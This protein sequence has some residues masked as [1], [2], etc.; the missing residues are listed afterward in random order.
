MQTSTFSLCRKHVFQSKLCFLE[1][2][3]IITSLCWLS[4]PQHM[5]TTASPY[6]SSSEKPFSPKN[7]F[8]FMLCFFMLDSTLDNVF[9]CFSQNDKKGC[10]LPLPF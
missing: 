6:I 4:L 5:K 7:L 8:I 9:Y 1:S 10:S 3:G 2:L